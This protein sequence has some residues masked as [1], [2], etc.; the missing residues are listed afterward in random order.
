MEFFCFLWQIFTSKVLIE[1]FS[2]AVCEPTANRPENDFSGLFAVVIWLP[3]VKKAVSQ[4][5]FIQKLL[6]RSFCISDRFLVLTN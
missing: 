1:V 6:R 5:F 4:G 3:R 2:S